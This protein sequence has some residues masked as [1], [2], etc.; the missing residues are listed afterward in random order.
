M[1]VPS[2]QWQRGC[3]GWRVAGVDAL[4]DI[5]PRLLTVSH[6]LNPKTFLGTYSLCSHAYK[7]VQRCITYGSKTISNALTKAENWALA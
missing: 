6:A 5:P 7:E 3:L 1:A 2:H 4:L